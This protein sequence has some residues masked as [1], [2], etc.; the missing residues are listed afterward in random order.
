MR[1]KREIMRAKREIMRAKREKMR[2]KRE[3]SPSFL[4]S[5]YLRVKPSNYGET[6][7]NVYKNG[8]EG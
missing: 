6:K 1:A 7:S 8:E 5:R 3:N 4:I 2:A